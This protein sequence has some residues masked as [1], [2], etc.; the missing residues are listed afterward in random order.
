MIP[1]R[2][3]PEPPPAPIP[4]ADLSAEAVAALRGWMLERDLSFTAEEAVAAGE[5]RCGTDPRA[6]ARVLRAQPEVACAEGR[7]YTARI[8]AGLCRFVLRPTP[9]ER[10]R[11]LLVAGHRLVPFAPAGAAEQEPP[12]VR[13]ELPDGTPLP[14][15]RVEVPREVAERCLRLLPPDQAQALLAGGTDPL[16]LP[17]YRLVGALAAAARAG[18]DLVAT[19]FDFRRGAYL[20]GPYRDDQPAERADR[21]ERL[22]DALREVLEDPPPGPVTAE[23]Q[24]LHAVASCFE[25]WAG[26]PVSPPAES[27]AGRRE[28]GIVE[29]EGTRR[30][31]RAP[32]PHQAGPVSAKS[33][34]VSSAT[35]A[36]AADL[37]VSEPAVV[38]PAPAPAAEWRSLFSRL[39]DI[40]SPAPTPPG[41]EGGGAPPAESGSVRLAWRLVLDPVHPLLVPYL[42][43]ASRPGTWSRGKMLSPVELERAS[44]AWI[45]PADR[46][47]ARVLNAALAGGGR[48][49]LF[50]ALE[51]LVRHPHVTWDEEGDRAVRIDAEDLRLQVEVGAAGAIGLLPAAGGLVGGRGATAT[52]GAQGLILVD[53][54]G[55]RV[56]LARATPLAL[57]LLQELRVGARTLPAEAA[58]ELLSRIPLLAGV[59]PVDLPS[60]LQGEETAPDPRVVLRLTP[61]RSAGLHLALRVRPLPTDTCL[62][63][64]GEGPIEVRATVGHRRLWARRDLAEESARATAQ[65]EALGLAGVTESAA[66]EWRILDDEAALDFIEQLRPRPREGLVIEWP[67][68]TA[69]LPTVQTAGPDRLRVEIEEDDDSFRFDGGVEVD[70]V[71]V[72]LARIL[73]R[74]RSGRKYL[75]VGDGKWVRIS[76]FLAERLQAL[77]QGRLPG[78]KGLP[79]EK[80]AAPV[81]AEWVREAGTVQACRAW[82][83]LMRRFESAQGIDPAPPP[84]FLGRMRPYQQEG[85]AWMRR[86]A[87]WGVGGCLADDMGLGKTVQTL[88]VLAARA[89]GGPALIV[90][91]TSVEGNWLREARSFCPGLEA[92]T[93]RRTDRAAGRDHF[94]PGQ[95]VVAS[96]GLVMRDA[97]RLARTSWHTLVLDEAQA[98]KNSHTRTAQAV[99]ALRADWRLALT[100]TPVENRLG[101][102]WSLFRAVCPG[103]LGTWEHFAHHFAGPI[104]RERDESR[105]D[106]LARLVRPFLLRRT[107]AEVLTELPP[108]TEMTLSVELSPEERELYDV[109]RLAAVD[110]L[111]RTENLAE[112]DRRMHA[113]AALTELR[114]LAC[115]PR[116]VYPDLQAESSK[117][118]L[119]LERVEELRAGG[120][121]ALVFSQFTRHLDLVRRELDARGI[122]YQYLDGGTTTRKRQEQVDAFQRGDA[123][124]FLISLKA[125]GTGLNLTAADYVIHLDPW[126]NPAVEDQAT[127]RAHRMGQTRPVIVIRL[128]ATGTVEERVLALHADKRDLVAGLLDG[129]DQAARLSVAEMVGLLRGGG[130]G[131]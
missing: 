7:F 129:A 74:L 122:R 109:A 71:L 89:R 101:D 79:V 9:F 86:L 83:D 4:A 52:L 107:K 77:A 115:H 2:P 82:Q 36:P 11:A 130:A 96:Y 76:R 10:D 85:Y 13:L 46:A 62:F 119:F 3:A 8:L 98:L 64:P 20:L 29:G 17:A 50:E 32:S 103:L 5:G 33:T 104:A 105:R 110:R 73:D 41:A 112:A 48:F 126:W 99:R 121:R 58:E 69:G 34:G 87:E 21:E 84:G 49:D 66:W 31:V 90:A 116:L 68:G 102:L 97:D 28:F 106:E 127:D 45:G 124:L 56:V 128:V 47:A 91:P 54:A 30:F 94:R 125:G 25:D 70:G 120:H 23:R 57:T 114:Q 75:P 42:Q 1:L 12:A 53:R 100:G 16:P 55:G 118:R 18:D 92:L 108:R 67:A 44:E 111:D 39:D 19:C 65:R 40:L 6:V 78:K 131:A 117:M 88:A 59:L 72:S 63:R 93:W 95:L 43:K 26:R 15:E 61:H 35:R 81:L 38:G 80:S 123:E 51:R 27:L 60:E 37:P 113:L 22:A 14:R 24:I